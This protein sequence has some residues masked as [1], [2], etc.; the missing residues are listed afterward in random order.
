MKTQIELSNELIGKYV[1][2]YMY[3]D[4]V[5][6]GKIIGIKGKRTLILQRIAAEKQLTKLEFHVGGFAANCSNQYDQTWEYIEL[7]ETDELKVLASFSRQYKIQ[8]K[9]LRFYDFNF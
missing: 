4:V 5:P 9:P 1:N 2:H 8:D 7:Q 6:L 3:S